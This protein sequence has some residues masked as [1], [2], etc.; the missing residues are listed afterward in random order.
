M[1]YFVEYYPFAG[2]V[3]VEGE[4]HVPLFASMPTGLEIVARKEG[5]L[6]STGGDCP[7]STMSWEIRVL[8][9][10]FCSGT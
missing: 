2:S 9:K 3:E 7:S 4:T 6:R 8:L 1:D 5:I 10:I